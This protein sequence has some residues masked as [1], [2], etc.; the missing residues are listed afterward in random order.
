[1]Y[2]LKFIRENTDELRDGLRKRGD[3]KRL[4]PILELDEKRRGIIAEVEVL[5]AERN[6][7]SREIGEIMKKGGNADEIRKDV[8]AIGDKIKD[9]DDDLKAIDSELSEKISWLPNI[10]HESVPVGKDETSNVEVKVWGKKPDFHFPVKD[11]LDLGASLNILDF[12]KSAKVTGSGFPLY[13]GKGAALERALINFML[14]IHTKEHGYKEVFPPFLV[15]QT[16][17]F[18]TGQI[19]KLEEDMYKCQDDDLYL[20]PT[21]EVPITNMH[22]DENLRQ[23]NLPICYAGYTACFRREAGSYGKDTRGFLRVHQFNKVELVKIVHPEDSYNEHEKLTLDAERILEMLEIPYRRIELCT[24]DLGFS[25][26]KCYDLEVWSPANEKWLEASSCSN[27]EDFQ[28]R[29]LNLRFKP[30]GGG[31]NQFVHTLNGSGVATSRLMVSL[32]ECNQTEEG[33]VM[34][35]KVLVQ[36][37]GFSVIGFD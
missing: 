29:R 4:N 13:V 20:I 28:A 32:L 12:E 37:T 26:A 7:R 19:P 11:H 35:P 21:A 22:R 6:K 24:G 23:K 30:E 27:F 5:K 9:Y 36:Y 33:T 15:N 31:K 17:L 3:E 25:A 8:K 1:M 10:P 2:N 34:V 14:D 18:S 16:S